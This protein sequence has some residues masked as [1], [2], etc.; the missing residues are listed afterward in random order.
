MVGWFGVQYTPTLVFDVHVF[1]WQ[2]DKNGQTRIR[3]KNRPLTPPKDA[4][5]KSDDNVCGNN[6]SSKPAQVRVPVNNTTHI[7]SVFVV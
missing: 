1:Q 2:K 5:S 3:N 6:T 7:P 4:N